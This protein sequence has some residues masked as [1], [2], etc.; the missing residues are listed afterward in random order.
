MTRR[1]LPG[2]WLAVLLSLV[3]SSAAAA[4]TGLLV[5]THGGGD[6][7]S[8]EAREAVVLARW[9]FGPAITAF[10][11]GEEAATAG[12]DAAVDSLLRQG[13]RAVVVVPLLDSAHRDLYQGVQYY[14]G[15]VDTLP[16]AVAVPTQVQYRPPPVPTRVA[17]VLSVD[18][19]PDGRLTVSSSRLGR[20]IGI[21]ARLVAGELVAS[22]AGR[23]TT[24]ADV[25]YHLSAVN[26]TAT[27]S[28]TDGFSTPMSVTV[29]GS[30]TVRE[31]APDGVVDLFRDVPGLD[32]EGVGTSQPRPIIRGLVG[33]R[34]LL[35][36][37]G[38]RLNNSR[39]EQRRGELPALVEVSGVERVEVVRGASSVLYGSDAIGGVVN[40][41]TQ[42]PRSDVTGADVSGTVAYRYSTVDRQSKPSGSVVAHLGR[43][44]LRAAGSFRDAEPYSAPGGSFGEVSLGGDTPVQ[45]TGVRDYSV[46][47]YL[48]RRLSG[49]QSAFVK[50]ERY[51]AEETGFGFVEP[52]EFGENLPRVQLVFPL[53]VFS[54]LTVGYDGTGVRLPFADNLD[55]RAY[56]QSNE[57]QFNTNVLAPFGPPAPAG[58]GVE[59]QTENFTDVDTYGFRFEATKAIGGRQVLTYGMDVFRDR[60]RNTDSSTT[61]VTGFGPPRVSGRGTPRVPY[62]GF[63]SFGVFLQDDIIVTRRASAIVGVR[64]QDVRAATQET[65]GLTG[66][67]LSATDRTLVGAANLLY[68]VTDELNVVASVGRAFRSPNLVERFFSG[69][70]PEGSGVWISNPDL[71]AETSLNL[72]AGVKYRSAMLQGE[73]YVFHNVVR[74]G[75][76]IEATG[77]TVDGVPEYQNVNVDELRFSGVELSVAAGFRN[78]ISLRAGFSRLSAKDLANPDLPVGAGYSY[79]LSTALRYTDSRGRFWGEYGVRH[80]GSR[81]DVDLGTSPVGETIPAFTVHHVRGGVLLFGHQRLGIAVENLTNRLYAEAPNVSFFRPEPKRNVILTWTFQF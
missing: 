77:D 41:I 62:A 5:A 17:P 19:A 10:L 37:D 64:Y 25:V 71:E 23:P 44:A 56:W 60:S 78:G 18:L 28:E 50:Y 66:P 27:R 29:L 12:W 33:Q 75:I 45:D 55:V 39:R 9:P 52:D 30:E 57:R 61:T 72:E 67:T 63:R 48:G 40:L 3:A 20:Q 79:K 16:V 4:Q 70:S 80:N 69:P 65:P 53:Q 8:R 46:S 13:A 7:W 81:E 68:R 6:E 2:L 73:G 1:S 24:P 32:V 35:L 74:N 58:A 42:R 59:V 47:A 26:V 15:L 21:E 43:W 36:E 54:R 22:E 38:L 31:R 49:H 11:T 34:I 76:R 14:A 51:R